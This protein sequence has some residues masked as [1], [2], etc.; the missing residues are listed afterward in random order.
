MSFSSGQPVTRVEILSSVRDDSLREG[1][2]VTLQCDADGD[3][4]FYEWSRYNNDPLPT[5]ADVR[6]S[7]L[8]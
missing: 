7:V 8:M 6:D 5:N 1:D 3:G 4:V 2:R